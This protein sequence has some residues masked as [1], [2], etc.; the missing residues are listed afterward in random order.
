MVIIIN[1]PN[2]IYFIYFFYNSR[3]KVF[4]FLSNYKKKIEFNKKLF[5]A[6]KTI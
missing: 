3:E 1:N 5:K 6:I 4:D 2:E